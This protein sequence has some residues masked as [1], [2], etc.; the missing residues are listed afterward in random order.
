MTKYMSTKHSFDSGEIFV[1]YSFVFSR[2]NLWNFTKYIFD[3]VLTTSDSFPLSNQTE[4][5]GCN[6]PFSDD[7]RA[8]DAVGTQM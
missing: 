3:N 8:L 1:L 2:N 6:K 7:F 5:V 4:I